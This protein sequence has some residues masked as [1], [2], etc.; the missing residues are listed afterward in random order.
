[1]L[2]LNVSLKK[3]SRFVVYCLIIKVLVCSC[4]TATLTFYHVGFCLSRT[5]LFFFFAVAVSRDS[6]N[7]LSHRFVTVKNFFTYFSTSFSEFFHDFFI[8]KLFIR[9]FC[10]FQPAI[11]I[12]A[13]P[14]RFV[15][16][17]RFL[18]VSATKLILPLSF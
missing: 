14:L 18:P 5:F 13:K 16:L 1:M 17:C 10:S 8:Y 9:S 6:F 11:H 2:F 4:F 15:G 3:F 12:P 7:R